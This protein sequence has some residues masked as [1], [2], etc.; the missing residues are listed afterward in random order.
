MNVG[1]WK[2]WVVAVVDCDAGCVLLLLVVAMV[3]SAGVVVLV[4]IDGATDGS[5]VSSGVGL[6]ALRCC[7][8]VALCCCAVVVAVVVGCNVS[9]V[10]MNCCRSSGLVL[11]ERRRIPVGFVLDWLYGDEMC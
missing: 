11:A 8:V 1:G 6:G 10:E 5:V 4:V 2:A 3:G 7:A 9:E